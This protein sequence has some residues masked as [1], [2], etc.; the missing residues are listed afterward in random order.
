MRS[1][2]HVTR[3]LAAAA[4]FALPAMAAA[5]NTKPIVAILSFDNNSIGKDAKDYDGVG[6]GIQDLLIADMANNANLR[7]VDRERIQKVLEEQNLTKT[8]A[9]DPTTAVR[10][11]KI[12]GAQYV[13]Y[14]GFMNTPNGVVLTAHTTDMETSQIQNPQKVNGKS[15]DVLGLISA[16][17]TKLNGLKLE[18][19]PGRRADA[20]PST[21]KQPGAAAQAGTPAGKVEQYAKALP[22][23][24]KTV[25]LD[26][27]TARLYANA[28]DEMDKK[29]SK[30]AAALF[31]QVVDKFP[32]FSPAADYLAKVS[33]SGN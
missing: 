15:D 21:D 11:G 20:T 33:Q 10:L 12:F 32:E 4:S 3:V 23:K 31:K 25:K 27:V 8:G 29:N 24:A 6:K 26:L 18:A 19:K 16:M 28:L 1:L 5:Q 7:L 9:I 2:S 30:K 17:S 22:P 13:I 14:G